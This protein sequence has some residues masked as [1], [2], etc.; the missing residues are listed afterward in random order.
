MRDSHVGAFGVIAGGLALLGQFA[1]LS[2]LSGRERLLAL[3]VA[4]TLSRWAMV[5]ALALFPA[6]RISGLGAA[7]QGG[8][9]RASVFVGTVLALPF[10]LVWG[11][12]GIAVFV[13]TI[14]LGLGCGGLLT[15]RL[16][17]LTGDSYGAIAV[18]VETAVLFVAVATAPR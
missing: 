12:T 18:V 15:R 17:G 2:E 3:V 4:F 14:A 13:V 11:Q 10:V 1:C 8:A 7:F 16:G 5:V 9:G 6:A